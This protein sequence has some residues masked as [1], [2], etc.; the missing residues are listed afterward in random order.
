MNISVGILGVGA[1]LPER[2]MTNAELEK[3][4]NTTDEWIVERT[5]IKSKAYC[6]S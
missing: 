3:M 6:G 4:V 5:G 2:V 1:Y